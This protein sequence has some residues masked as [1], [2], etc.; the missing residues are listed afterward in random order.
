VE[1]TRRPGVLVCTPPRASAPPRRSVAHPVSPPRCRGSSSTDTEVY[2]GG[3][4]PPFFLCPLLRSRCDLPS[5]RSWKPILLDLLLI[6]QPTDEPAREWSPMPGLTQRTGET[7]R[8]DA[9]AA[10]TTAFEK[11]RDASGF[12]T[13]RPNC[14]RDRARDRAGQGR[15][16]GPLRPLRTVL[17]AL[18]PTKAPARTT[19]GP[20]PE[21]RPQISEGL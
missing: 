1:K 20:A 7:R 16:S 2:R 11:N 12:P 13:P 9:R 19:Q 21:A 17:F 18:G 15:H 3:L 5:L 10:K 8:S 4:L 6:R 14:Y